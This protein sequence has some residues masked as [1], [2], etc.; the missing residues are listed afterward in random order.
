MKLGHYFS[1][2]CGLVEVAKSGHAHFVSQFEGMQSPMVVVVGGHVSRHMRIHPPSG[3]QET[4]TAAWSAF[5]YFP[6]HPIKTSD[7]R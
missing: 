2:Y 7:K 3:S 5:S 4:K 1:H 6:L